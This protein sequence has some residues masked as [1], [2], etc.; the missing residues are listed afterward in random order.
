M[1]I[2]PAMLAPG[3]TVDKPLNL[4]KG[5][6][7][8]AAKSIV[9]RTTRTRTPVDKLSDYDRRQL[10]ACKGDRGCMR[11]ILMEE[12]KTLMPKGQVYKIILVRDDKEGIKILV[13]QKQDWPE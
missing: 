3:A 4:R 8:F 6:D 11:D 5:I 1:T 2:F 9:K 12:E 13:K 7:L 10:A